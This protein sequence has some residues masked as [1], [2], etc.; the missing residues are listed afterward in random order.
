MK[1]FA[2]SSPIQPAGYFPDFLPDYA[3]DVS[4]IN[5]E[6]IVPDFAQKLSLQKVVKAVDMD[7]RL[8]PNTGGVSTCANDLAVEG[9][10]HGRSSPSQ[11][12]LK[13]PTSKQKKKT[14]KLGIVSFG[15]SI[16]EHDHFPK[17]I[18]QRS[19]RSKKCR[20]K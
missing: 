14:G 18:K 11:E 9:V 10:S 13:I 5:S 17:A 6:H 3:S 1:G 2:T 4:S 19:Q 7:A 16:T 8:P 12:H 15:T 20:K